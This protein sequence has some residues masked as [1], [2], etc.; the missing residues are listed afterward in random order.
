M[1]V[2]KQFHLFNVYLLRE[3]TKP[4]VFPMKHRSEQVALDFGIWNAPVF[5]NTSSKSPCENPHTL[6]GSGYT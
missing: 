4:S 3:S 5:P 2:Y 6:P 1:V